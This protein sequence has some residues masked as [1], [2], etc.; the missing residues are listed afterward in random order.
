MKADYRALKAKTDKS[1]TADQKSSRHEEV[2]YVGS[3]AEIMTTDPKILSIE[4]PVESKVL[5]T[6]EESSTWLLDSGA[7]YHVTPHRSQFRQFSDRHVRVGNS[8]HCAIIGIGTVELNLPGGS[9]LV[10]HNV[11]HV[12]ELSSPLISVLRALPVRQTGSRI[13]PDISTKRIEPIRFGP[14]GRLWPDATSVSRRCF[15]LR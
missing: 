1:Y 10:L 2:N 8:Q 4:N 11:R 3:S 6:T 13:T 7:S 12:P 9:T 5:L 14:L 15:I